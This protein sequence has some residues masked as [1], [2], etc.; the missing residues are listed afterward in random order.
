[1]AA[2]APV[3]AANSAALSQASPAVQEMVKTLVMAADQSLAQLQS[4]LATVVEADRLSTLDASLVH[5]KAHKMMSADALRAIEAHLQSQLSPA[6]AAKSKSGSLGTVLSNGYVQTGLVIAGLGG[7]AAAGGGGGGGGGGDSSPAPKPSP[8]PEKPIEVTPPAEQPAPEEP[9]TPPVEEPAP[10]EPTT[11]PAP[12]EPTT[13]PPPP[14]ISQPTQAEYAFTGGMEVT[15]VEAAHARGYTGGSAVIAILDTGFASDH[16]EL[17][18]QFDGFYNA[19]TGSE[20]AADAMDMDGHG[21]HVAGIIGAKAN[22]YMGVGYAP[23]ASLLG[24]RLGDE[25]GELLTS[26]EQTAAAFRWAR[27]HGA[28]FINSSWGPDLKI[29]DVTADQIE[30]YLGPELA[31]FRTGAQSDVIYV[32]AN[33]NDGAMQPQMYAALPQLFPE[34]EGNWVAVANIDAATGELHSTSQ[35]CGDARNWCISAPGTDIA[36]P[37]PGGDQYYA[38]MTGT[39]MAAP[40]VTAAL[41]VLKDAFPMLSNEQIL[42]R[43]FFTADKS[44]IYANMALYGQG[45]MDLDAATAP[46]G[47]LSIYNGSGQGAPLAVTTMKLGS[48]FGTSNPLQGVK[49]MA[50]DAQGAGF[51]TDLGGVVDAE[52]YEHDMVAATA[53]LSRQAPKQISRGHGMSLT[54]SFNGVDSQQMDNM[55][56]GFAGTDGLTTRFGMV[57]DAD[58]LAGGMNFAGV[59]QQKVSFTA[60]YW[61]S[62]TDVSA[63]GFQ[64]GVDMLG[65]TFAVTGMSSA[66]R[67]GFAAS[68]SHKLG[69]GYTNTLEIGQVSG[70]DSLFGT[71]SG[72]AL[73]FGDKSETRFVGMRG[74]YQHKSMTLFHSAYLGESDVSA[75]GLISGLDTVVTSS[76]VVGGKFDQGNKQFGLLVAQ[77]LKVESAEANLSFI[78]GYQNGAYTLG[79][80]NVDL[81]PSGRQINTELYFATSTRAIDDIKLSFMRMDQ[82]GHNAY[83]KAEHAMTLSL[84]TRF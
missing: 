80:V 29:A 26:T 36:A 32:W 67:A 45:L 55:V 8:A 15:G 82:P 38:V 23:D 20:T 72:G 11:P 81:A 22:D 43:L 53:R 73:S 44:G 49:V 4:V 75:S 35:A 84:G 76:W 65:G 25:N 13:P 56:M 9:T 66:E 83:A 68:F 50:L 2:S 7:L 58:V 61:M 41:A 71:E 28:D 27:E 39:S 62:D 5:I 1:M 31:E 37:A 6:R 21:T 74:E 14:P 10:E 24:V 60:P 48:A 33:G 12:E 78:N 3:S 54:Y 51:V 30:T 19:Y 59:S 52:A 40:A 18:G 17:N 63:V 79:S 42:E 64:Q 16:V 34:L 69:N 46:V 47:Q 77:P 57:S 70:Q